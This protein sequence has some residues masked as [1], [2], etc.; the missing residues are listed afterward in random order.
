MIAAWR[1]AVCDATLDIAT[2][3]AWS[4]PNRT[5]DDPHHVMHLLTGGAEPAPGDDP[6][7]YVTYRARMAWHAFAVANGMTD[8]ATRALA[9]DVAAGFIVTPFAANEVL[10]NAFD[11]EVW[12]KDETNNVGG[13]H[14]GR[15]LVSTMLHLRAA[16][17]LGLTPWSSPTDRSPL[18]IASCGNA[19]IA[20]ATLAQRSDWPIE[21]F[22]PDWADRPT[23]DLLASLGAT[24]TS[25]PRTAEPGDPAMH[26]FR[27][28]VRDGAIPFSVQGPDNATCLDG[29]RTIGWE[30]ADADADL[31][32]VLVQVGGG[33]LASCVGAGLGAGVAL[34]AVQAEGCA[35]LL[36]AYLAMASTPDDELGRHWDA[37]MQP[38]PN[39]QSAATGI[40]DDETYDWIS[41]IEAMRSSDGRPVVATEEQ[42]V[43]AASLAK[44]TGI[45]VSPTGAAGV[46]GLI[47]RRDA[48]AGQRVAVVFSGVDRT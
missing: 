35:P 24:I 25:C 3:L 28:A 16:E 21:V 9:A 4:C 6:N 10:S 18:A 48:I 17:S 30:M 5:P 27:Q 32:R 20:A 38:W 45:D 11:A 43:E 31:D 19:A 41:V 33:A 15:H 47:A 22:V 14:K 40:L 1:C 46:A 7:P 34:D 39:P 8:A 42:I 12:V 44:R 37:A 36:R 29:G 13:S 23:L 2:P 26:R